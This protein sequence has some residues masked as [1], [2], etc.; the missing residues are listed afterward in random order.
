MLPEPQKKNCLRCHGTQADIDLEIAR[1]R[2]SRSASPK[3]LADNLEDAYVHPMSEDAYSQMEA[4]SVTCT[5]C[6]SPHRH[7]PEVRVQGRPIGEALPSPKNPEVFE[8]EL[9]ESC[10]GN[11]GASTFDLTDISRLLDPGNRSFHPIESPAVGSSP[12]LIPALE[13]GQINCTDCHGNSNPNGPRGLHGSQVPAILLE[14]YTLSDGSEESPTTY[15]MCYSCHRRQ[16]VLD[17]D[18]FP[19]H[20]MHIVEIKASCST[21]HNPHGSVTNR[22]LITFGEETS[23]SGVLPSPSTGRLEFVSDMP[24]SGACYLS[25][26]GKD[27]APAAYGIESEMMKALAPLPVGVRRASPRR[28][29]PKPRQ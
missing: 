12:S 5:S 19:E 11:Q 26:H 10:H 9:C 1:G 23:T 13:G 3:K 21:C 20:E 22:A 17:S 6:H 2:L 4:N 15:A 7:T 16:M 24:G 27:H 14:N 28:V 25:C 8:Y 18:G 29:S